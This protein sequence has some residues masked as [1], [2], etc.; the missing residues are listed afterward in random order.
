MSGLQKGN[1]AGLQVHGKRGKSAHASPTPHHTLLE[2]L[3]ARFF[4]QPL[5]ALLFPLDRPPRAFL[6]SPLPS[7]L[8]TQK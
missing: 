5:S 7:L 3:S 6:F 1:F 4:A 2:E 8:S